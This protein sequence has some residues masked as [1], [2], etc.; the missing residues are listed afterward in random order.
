VLSADEN[1]N[2]GRER[3]NPRHYHGNSD[4]VDERTDPDEDQVDCQQEH[5]EIFGDVHMSFLRQT[6]CTCTLKKDD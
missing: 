3:Q 6:A 5:S 4:C 1:E 2:S